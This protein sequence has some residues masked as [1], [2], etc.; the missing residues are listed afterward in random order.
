M[1]ASATVLVMALKVV[2][3]K[4]E[5]IDANIEGRWVRASFIYV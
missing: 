5:S 1:A 4:V 3:V 2:V